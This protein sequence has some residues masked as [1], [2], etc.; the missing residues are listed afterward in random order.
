MMTTHRSWL[1][2]AIVIAT[3]ALSACETYKQTTGTVIG[4]IAGGVIGHQIGSGSGNTIAT[5]AGTI[6]G[7]YIG[8]KV[9]RQMDDKD[10]QQTAAALETTPTYE[11]SSW[12][13]PDTGN[14][15]EVTPT[16]TFGDE[17]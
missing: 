6:L 7:G 17:T 11:T 9:G 14:R 5:I 3:I 2:F 1:V 13:N 12:T 16:R 8:G 4:A 10:R 15:Y